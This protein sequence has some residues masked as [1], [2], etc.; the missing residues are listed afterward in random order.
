MIWNSQAF[1]ALTK[2]FETI[3]A[4]QETTIPFLL[5]SGPEHV[6]KTTATM[7]H[8][9]RY[10]WSYLQQD[11]LPLYDCSRWLWKKHTLKISVWP[12]DQ[13]LTD[14][15]WTHYHNLG[16]REIIE[17]LSRSSVSGKKVLFLE[18]IERMTIEAANALL[19]SLEEPMPW[20]MIIATTR[21]SSFLLDTIVSRAMIIRFHPVPYADMLDR[22]TTMWWTKH[23]NALIRFAVASSAGSPW[24]VA[25]L[26]D[27]QFDSWMLQ[28]MSDLFDQLLGFYEQWWSLSE[29]FQRFQTR[30]KEYGTL[31][32]IIDALVYSLDPIKNAAA[33]DQ[34]L[35]WKK[36][37]QTT[38]SNDTICFYLSMSNVPAYDTI[39]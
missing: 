30:T 28:I 31:Q 39:S 37:A 25:Q 20:K 23:S 21:N 36:L 9:Q 12:K 17:R 6:G 3:T 29:Q 16:S 27:G 38:V 18:N 26:L 7:E 24:T 13:L 2:I 22:A 4:S 11:C 1:A 14:D 8:L 33:S 15:E 32:S 19:K 35:Y 10:L 34:L 5:L